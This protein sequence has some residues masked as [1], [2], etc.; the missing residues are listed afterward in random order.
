MTM[1]QSLLFESAELC[2][3]REPLLA[4][5]FPRWFDVYKKLMGLEIDSLS[6][7]KDISTVEYKPFVTQLFADAEQEIIHVNGQVNGFVYSE[8]DPLKK[9]LE[10]SFERNPDFAYHLLFG[11]VALSHYEGN[12]PHPHD[13]LEFL[14]ELK[15]KVEERNRQEGTTGIVSVISAELDPQFH[16]LAIDQGKSVGC[17][18]PHFSWDGLKDRF[19]FSDSAAYQVVKDFYD[20]E[21]AKP[22]VKVLSSMKNVS[23]ASLAYFLDKEV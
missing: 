23:S 18:M 14:F 15:E 10:D 1:L 7:I 20:S 17:E 21:V 22:G 9:T 6:F 11:P 3:L 16:F 19:E 2:S 8:N 5:D 13:Y 4:N 12:N